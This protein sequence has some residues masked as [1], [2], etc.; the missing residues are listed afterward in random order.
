[1]VTF[2]S[3]PEDVL[4]TAIEQLARLR[5]HL[6]AAGYS[7]EWKEFE[8]AF[9][10]TKFPG[11]TLAVCRYGKPAFRIVDSWVGS[12]YAEFAAHAVWV[13]QENHLSLLTTTGAFTKQG[14]TAGGY[15]TEN[16][17]R[18]VCGMQISP[19]VSHKLLISALNAATIS[20]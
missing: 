7:G 17:L 15:F 12:R 9:E 13:A 10:L 1:M 11:A 18:G 2:E 8:S 20:I 16:R 6:H 3:A 4:E 5:D 14:A 19:D